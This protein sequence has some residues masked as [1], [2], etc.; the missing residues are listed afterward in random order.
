M[1]TFILTIIS[2][3]FTC[4]LTA[5]KNKKMVLEY[6]DGNGNY[7]KITQDSI[8]YK[9]ITKEMSSS[10]LYDGGKPAQKTITEKEFMAVQN[11]FEDIFE[12]KNIHIQ[13]RM[14]TSGQLVINRGKKE[15]KK[16]IIERSEEQKKL[17]KLLK[18][19][20]TD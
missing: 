5:Q 11:K 16:V 1:R 12:T 7:Y 20:L 4:T 17:E 15:G 18:S 10:G 13:Y 19:L 8:F 6:A 2:L 14:K 3:F 9:P